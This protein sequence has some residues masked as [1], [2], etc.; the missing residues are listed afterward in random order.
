MRPVD[1]ATT[2]GLTALALVTPHRLSRGELAAY[3]AANCALAGVLL[4]DV[5][6]QDIIEEPTD[7]GFA[8]VLPESVV[9]SVEENPT[10]T[11]LALG[12]GGAALTAAFMP[13]GLKI[14][15]AAHQ[16]LER[17]GVQHP[18]LVL[19]GLTATSAWLSTFVPSPSAR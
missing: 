5:V 11:L 2:A 10:A 3:V 12:V 13:V 4:A 14:D 8:E 18:R 1:F 16:W 9:R 15:R 17:R 19:A 6:R 7:E